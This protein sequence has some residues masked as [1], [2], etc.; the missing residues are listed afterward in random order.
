[1]LRSAR[2][3]GRARCRRL[4]RRSGRR[5]DLL[6]RTL[7]RRLVGPP[8]QEAGPMAEPAAADMIVTNFDDQ[9]R[10]QRLPFSG[11]LGAPPAGAARRVAGESGRLDKAFE[12]PGQRLA[13]EV[14]QCGGKSDVIEL[15][16]AVVEAEQ[17]GT[18]P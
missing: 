17:Q 5:L 16:F 9:F 14:V 15:A 3:A 6:E 1:M 8:S 18:H 12:L 7:A 10:P 2:T 4:P 13:V 11:T